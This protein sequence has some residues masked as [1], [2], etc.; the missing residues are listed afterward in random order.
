LVLLH[1]HERY[2]AGHSYFLHLEQHQSHREI[3]CRLEQASEWRG[4]EGVVRLGCD[5][6]VFPESWQVDQQISKMC[7]WLIYS[8]AN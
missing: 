2:L 5:G 8:A 4:E 1:F 6:K 3:I 7:S